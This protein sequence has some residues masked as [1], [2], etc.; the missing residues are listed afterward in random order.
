MRVWSR[1]KGRTKSNF[2]Y[3]SLSLSRVG[4]FRRLKS[5]YQTKSK[6]LLM[7]EAAKLKLLLMPEAAKSKLLLMQK[8][9]KLKL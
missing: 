9:T 2:W 6:L 5:P 1:K 7:P 4:W 8:A 3:L